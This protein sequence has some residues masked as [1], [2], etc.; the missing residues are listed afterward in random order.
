MSLDKTENSEPASIVGP[1]HNWTPRWGELRPHG[2]QLR[3]WQDQTRF[4]LVPSGRR[5]GKTELAK[6]RLVEHLFRK[7]WHGAPGRY[8][9][10]APTHDQAKRIF[11]DDLKS[12][13]PRMWTGSISETDL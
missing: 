12:L 9:A 7:T 4:K 2:E 3:L 5:S 1:N 13:V 8:F 10:A 6:R 11:W